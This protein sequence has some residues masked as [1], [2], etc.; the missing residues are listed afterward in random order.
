MEKEIVVFL[1]QKH[2]AGTLTEAEKNEL[3]EFISRRQN[4]EIITATLEELLSK[5]QPLPEFEENRFM[6]LLAGILKADAIE[7]K[8]EEADST[9]GKRPVFS[10]KTI[11]LV[12]LAVIILGATGVYFYYF[13][14][15]ASKTIHYNNDSILNEVR[16][17]GNIAVLTLSDGSTMV[18]DSADTGF[19][20]QQGNAKI[21]KSANGELTYTVSG[22][23]NSTSLFN[24]ITTPH[25][26][27]YQV[28][29]SDGSRVKL[30]SFSSITYPTT[31]VGKERRV[32]ITG[33][34]YFEIAKNV[35]RPFRVKAYDMEVEVM[36]TEFNINAYTEEPAI[37]TTLMKGILKLTNN[38]M[39]LM[40]H[41]SQQ[42]QFDK[43]GKF[44]VGK[45]IDTNEVIAWK[46]GYFQFNNTD[47]K[48]VMR[49]IG[50]WYNVDIVY[51]K[52]TH[53]DQE[54]FGEIR[55]NVNLSEIIKML[56]KNSINCRLDGRSL[57]VMPFS[58]NN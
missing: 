12:L 3:T 10:R 25:G 44:S 46:N 24:T 13:N 29:L 5:E 54:V 45:N 7:D 21:I 1:L 31:F 40:L 20:A 57:I 4:K 34:A 2:I 58:E 6:P 50:R 51:E 16:P 39:M 32:T 52:G 30:N 36:S 35:K 26:G 49:Q 43:E 47:V 48:T 9:I 41:A 11:M 23:P 19:V 33:E 42:G 56:K 18:L 37:K 55:R 38:E 15:F 22:E 53:A 28:V 17:G 14:P 8:E 27:Q